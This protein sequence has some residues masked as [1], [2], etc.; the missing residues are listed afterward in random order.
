MRPT[1]ALTLSRPATEAARASH[2]A[3]RIRLREA[4]AEVIDVF[5][6][7]RP[8]TEFDAL[9]LAGGGDID[10]IEYEEQ[11]D[12]RIEHVDNDRDRVE[13]DITKVALERGVPVLG[14]CRG[15]QVL[16]WRFG[17]K[18]K[19]HVE[20]HRAMNGPIEPHLI[21]PVDG[22][23]LARICGTKPF[24]VNSRHHQVVVSVPNG[25]VPVA[26]VGGYVEAVETTDGRW[27]LG[28]QWHP[29]T[30]NDP[31]QDEDQAR[32]IFEAFVK[33]AEPV[34]AK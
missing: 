13:R 5:P 11:P 1:V 31:L 4:G 27:L 10:P 33:A 26:R 28:V 20:H 17:G 29:E 21:A 9:L 14:V 32:R 8:P 24:R 15:F 30:K 22:S 3:Y 7:D 34:R 18:L 2:E 23:L 12:Q 25:L 19:Q 6:T 16:N